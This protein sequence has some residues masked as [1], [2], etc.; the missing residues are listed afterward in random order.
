MKTFTSQT[1][2]YQK[3][4]SSYGPAEFGVSSYRLDGRIICIT[5]I[6]IFIL[7]GLNKK[8]VIESISPR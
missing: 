2:S 8:F 5:G 4:E 3:S 7:N 6:N 1:S